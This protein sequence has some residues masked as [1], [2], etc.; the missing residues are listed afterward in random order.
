MLPYQQLQM[1]DG[2]CVILAATATDSL[3]Q[4]LIESETRNAQRRN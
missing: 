1:G 2:N 4:R 3:H